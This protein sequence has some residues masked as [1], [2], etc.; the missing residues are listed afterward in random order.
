VSVSYSK[1]RQVNLLIQVKH[2]RVLAVSGGC[3]DQVDPEQKRILHHVLHTELPEWRLVEKVFKS[4]I[5]KHFKTVYLFLN[6]LTYRVEPEQ[7]WETFGTIPSC[8][9]DA[10][11][12]LVRTQEFRDDSSA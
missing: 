8:Y 12:E 10:Y 2:L 1:Y 6:D 3:F 11:F 4:N 9:E 7:E 5:S